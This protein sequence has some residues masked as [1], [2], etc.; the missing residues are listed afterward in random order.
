MER[1]PFPLRRPHNSDA[2]GTRGLLGSRAAVTVDGPTESREWG[3]GGRGAYSSRHSHGL[4]HHQPRRYDLCPGSWSLPV[5]LA[6]PTSQGPLGDSPILKSWGP[7]FS[8]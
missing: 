1:G 5:D 7:G 4:Q 2:H 3:R 6:A 8:S